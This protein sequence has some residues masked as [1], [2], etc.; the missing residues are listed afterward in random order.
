ML[1]N[2]FMGLRQEG[3]AAAAVAALQKAAH[4]DSSSW[5]AASSAA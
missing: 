5:M 3:K 2:A 4:R 1:F